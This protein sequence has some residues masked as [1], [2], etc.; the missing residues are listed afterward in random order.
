MA[1]DIP[2]WAVLLI[3]IAVL[4]TPKC[5]ERLKNW[6]IKKAREKKYA[7][8]YIPLKW[9]GGTCEPAT[10]LKGHWLMLVALFA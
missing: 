9:I 5:F 10:S 3:V 8:G 4:I 1:A 6:R 7:K 2:N